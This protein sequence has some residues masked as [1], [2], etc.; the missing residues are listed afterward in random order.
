MSILFLKLLLAHLLG[1][2]VFQPKRWVH[3]RKQHA[4]Y[5][6]LHIGIHAVL[7]LILFGNQLA[8]FW[9]VI[10][11]V[12]CTHLIID[13][14]KIYTERYLYP[15]S[16][17]LFVIDQ[18]AHLLVILSVIVYRYE[19]FA[20]W[21]SYLLSEK[22]LLFIIAI[23]LTVYVSPI[24]LRVFF[25][26]WTNGA[27]FLQKSKHSLTNA[28]MWIGIME[29]ILI[30]LFIQVGFLSGLGFLLGAKSIFRFGDLTNAKDT[31]Y[32]E[33]ILIG[34]LASFV[35]GILIGYALR[36]GLRYLG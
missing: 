33:Y 11:F 36:L 31:K 7:L 3:K 15:F 6:L 16:F 1:D 23:L 34:T 18:C 13:S 27:E 21:A 5:L 10:L 30:V 22:A 14:L 9:D 26:K 29:R 32:T 25:Q 24:M 4:G 20:E 28:G 2:F 8:I 12:I 19:V 17:R 35:V